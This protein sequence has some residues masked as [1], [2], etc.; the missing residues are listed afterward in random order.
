M[1]SRVGSFLIAALL[2]G[3]GDECVESACCGFAAGCTQRCRN[4]AERSGG[5]AVE[6][7]DVEIRFS[8][9]QMSLADCTLVVRGRDV[10]S[11]GQ[12]RQS[13]GADYRFVRQH[14]RISEAAQQ[15]HGRGVQHAARRG[16][17]RHSDESRIAS[18]SRR[19]DSGSSGGKCRRLA[20]S[21][22]GD[23]LRRGNGRS[24]ATGR[25]SRVTTINSPCSTRS[26]TS[27]PLLRRS[28]TLTDDIPGMYH[29]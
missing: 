27:P 25:P 5:F 28:R 24:S 23:A 19:S 2:L 4:G 10:R 20:M 11:D 16:R 6:C 22:A 14:R 1:S 15:D 9:L 7:L 13:D 12:F 8:L 29:R 18:M 17:S 26:R 3:F 21:S